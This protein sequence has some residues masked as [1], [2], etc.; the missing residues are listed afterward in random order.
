MRVVCNTR[1]DGTRV[2]VLAAVVVCHLVVA[3][4]VLAPAARRVVRPVRL[5][6]VSLLQP[7]PRVP[8]EQ[9]VLRVTV[10]RLPVF[11]APVVP[12]PA[13]LVRQD[14]VVG[15]AAVA[16]APVAPVVVAAARA[17]VPPPLRLTAQ[18]ARSWQ[19]RL[20]QRLEACKRYPAAARR[21]GVEGATQIAFSLDGAGR[22]AA[23][24]M[25]RTSGS[26]DLDEE[27]MR[28]LGCAGP[29]PPPPAGMAVPVRIS[30][31]I[32]FML[33]E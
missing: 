5:L 26:A 25:A 13:V 23:Q 4:M 32:R 10:P 18:A 30:T 22:V 17:V 15:R 20:L 1:L 31:V 11:A 33:D 8:V 24:A 12:A 14:R 6:T 3:V 29:F 7:A 19:D 21:S 2:A 28:L 27:A 9:E 16:P